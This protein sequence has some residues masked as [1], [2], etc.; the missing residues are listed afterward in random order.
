[1][2]DI[3]VYYFMRT[4]GPGG[5]ELLSKRRATL[6][7]IKG[8]GE[9][10][11]NSQIVVDHREVDDNGFVIR[12]TRNESDASNE[13]WSQIRSLELRA[14]SRDTDAQ[15][16]DEHSEGA[17]KYMLQLESRELRRQA[18]ILKMQLTGAITREHE[19]RSGKQDFEFA[20]SLTTG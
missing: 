20:D 9:A 5:A 14:D 16:L 12:G 19:P 18:N 10:V 8:K 17:L 15:K 7:A 4:R 2:T 6:E 3:Y 11:M 13:S 1:M